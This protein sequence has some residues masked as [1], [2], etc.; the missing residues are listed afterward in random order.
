MAAKIV[1]K[2][3]KRSE[4]PRTEKQHS[5]QADKI[6]RIKLGSTYSPTPKKGGIDAPSRRRGPGYT[7]QPPNNGT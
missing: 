5:N 1:R 3:N 7:P 4:V 2:K 6:L